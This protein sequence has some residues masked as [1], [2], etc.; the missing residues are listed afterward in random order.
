VTDVGPQTTDE[1]SPAAESSAVRMLHLARQAGF[2][3]ARHVSATMLSERYFAGR[4]DGL[5]TLRG[6]ELLVATT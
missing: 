4:E 1:P 3:H 2:R 5:K 6:E